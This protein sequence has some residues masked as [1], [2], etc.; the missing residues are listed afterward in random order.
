MEEALFEEITEKQYE[1]YSKLFLG[2]LKRKHLIKL[3]NKY[4]VNTKYKTT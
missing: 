2:K 1:D 4:Y 3:D